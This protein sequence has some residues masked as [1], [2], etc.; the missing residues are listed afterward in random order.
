MVSR[1]K[2]DSRSLKHILQ[3]QKSDYKR[4][5]PVD[6]GFSRTLTNKPSAAM[7]NIENSQRKLLLNIGKSFTIDHGPW[8]AI[9][10]VHD[11]TRE[12]RKDFDRN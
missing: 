5:P 2:L 1:S 4:K 8:T 3:N 7:N 6:K 12:R 11:F 10:I 9:V